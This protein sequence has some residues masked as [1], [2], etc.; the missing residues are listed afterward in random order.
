M[1]DTD[2]SGSNR[3]DRARQL[4]GLENQ[5]IVNDFSYWGN[6]DVDWDT[7]YQDLKF[8]DGWVPANWQA[9]NWRVSEH[10]AEPPFPTT[11]ATEFVELD[12]AQFLTTVGTDLVNDSYPP[13]AHILDQIGIHMP[14]KYQSI[15]QHYQACRIHRQMPG[16]MLWMHYDFSADED[17][18]Q[19]FVFLNDWA[20]G[21]VSLL[22]TESI[23]N[24]RSGD[25]YKVNG[26]V[27][28]HGAVNCGYGE[29][30]L[31]AIK[32]RSSK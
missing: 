30:W 14:D 18:E 26:H 2:K 21:Q 31:A 32:G 1:T 12:R 5:P 20:P 29:R 10:G 19:Y 25:V 16:Q 17:W 23:T 15:S 9:W 22:G 8:F 27:T 13:I 24:W 7:I 4:R 28:P 6:I 11:S 3:W